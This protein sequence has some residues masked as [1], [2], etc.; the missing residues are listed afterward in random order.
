MTDERRF[1]VGEDAVMRLDRRD[2]VA[3]DCLEARVADRLRLALDEYELG[4]R[5]DLEAR[6]QQHLVGSVGLADV[7]VVL[8]DLLR[9]HGRAD[10]DRHDD[11]REP[12]EDRLL[13]VTRAPT[14][15]PGREVVGTLEGR[16]FEISPSCWRSSQSRTGLA[17][18]VIRQAGVFTFG[19]PNVG[20]RTAARW[21][22]VRGEGGWS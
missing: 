21:G 15:H 2:R 22:G 17:G 1:E 3:D 11:E 20:R 14:A 16:H 13:A 7:G 12:P 8:I 18:S 9:P 6:V 19:D 5:V 4:L 10:G